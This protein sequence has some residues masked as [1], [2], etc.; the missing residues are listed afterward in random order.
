MKN[1]NEEIKKANGAEEL[2]DEMLDGVS[3]GLVQ[4]INPSSTP[5]YMFKDDISCKHCGKRN[6]DYINGRMICLDCK[7]DM[8]DRPVAKSEIKKTS[9]GRL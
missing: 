3:G 7:M 1:L 8:V 4:L 6:G 2:E 5:C 9:T